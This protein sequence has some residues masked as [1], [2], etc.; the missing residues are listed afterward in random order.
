MDWRRFL[1]S[2]SKLINLLIGVAV[3]VLAVG[4]FL[5]YRNIQHL[6]VEVAQVESRLNQGQ[7]LWKSF[8]P[9]DPSQKRELA[10][11]QDRLLRVLP[12][13]RELPGLLQDIARL[14][15]DYGLVDVAFITTEA[16]ISQGAPGSGTPQAGAPMPVQ[17]PVPA[18]TAPSAKPIE[19]VPV[20]VMFAGDY[21]DIAFFLDG[22]SRIPRLVAVQSLKIQRGFP[23][24]SAEVIVHAYYQKGDLPFP[25]K[26]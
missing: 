17:P 21:R 10:R 19:P 26:R 16:L 5:K 8:P 2:Y 18:A 14:A 4:C 25:A 3:L 15:R 20:K 9:L 22:L 13:E 11:A 24:Q 6:K 1:D 12:K 7:E 23:A